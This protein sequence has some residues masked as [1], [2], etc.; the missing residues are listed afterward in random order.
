MV[1][2]GSATTAP[3]GLVTSTQAVSNQ[4]D[5]VVGSFS[6]QLTQLDN[7]YEQQFGILANPLEKVDQRL[8]VPANAFENNLQ[9]ARAGLTAAVSSTVSAVVASAPSSTTTASNPATSIT[10]PTTTT[11]STAATTI[12]TTSTQIFSNAFTQAFGP[13]NSATNSVDS[14]LS[15]IF[16]VFQNQFQTSVTNLI[17]AISTTPTGAFQPVVGF[18]NGNG[19]TF[20]STG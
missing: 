15:S 18:T 2:N 17:S 4:L 1:T 19:V 7:A 9:F 12:G 16:G 8:G 5:R 13:S 20:T 10:S 14:E 11:S 3:A 6:S